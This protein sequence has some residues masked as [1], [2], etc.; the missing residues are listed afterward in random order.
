VK[1]ICI[2]SDQVEYVEQ[3]LDQHNI[4]NK[5]KVCVVSGGPS[6][7]CSIKNG[8]SV[9]ENI[10]KI[11][12]FAVSGQSRIKSIVLR[13]ESHRHSPALSN[14]IGYEMLIST[15]PFLFCTGPSLWTQPYVDTVKTI[16]FET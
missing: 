8:L 9:L 11:L 12:Y 15:Q 1:K 2:V 13:N 14:A 10:G 16:A 4:I 3:L 5:D 7:H 6:R